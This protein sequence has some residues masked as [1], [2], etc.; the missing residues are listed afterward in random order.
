MKTLANRQK[1]G[2]GQLAGFKRGSILE[3]QRA[4]DRAVLAASPNGPRRR[5]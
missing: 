3:K 2:E 4:A 5:V 1:N